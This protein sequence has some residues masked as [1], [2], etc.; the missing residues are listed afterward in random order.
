[1][2]RER[3]QAKTHNFALPY[4]W[5]GTSKDLWGHIILILFAVNDAIAAQHKE[6]EP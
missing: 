3:L 4:G 5:D 6:Q 1:M 2:E